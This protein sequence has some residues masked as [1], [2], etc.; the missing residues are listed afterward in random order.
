MSKRRPGKER[1]IVW[2]DAAP[3]RTCYLIDGQMPIVQELNPALTVNQAEYAGLARALIAAKEEGITNLEVRTDSQL[4]ARQLNQEYA[5]NNP[6]LLKC[7]QGIWEY[8]KQ[9]ESVVF[10]WI[11]REQNQ[12]GKVLG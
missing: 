4:A 2:T 3:T 8:V 12:A 7:A 1:T 11:P 6:T 9:F 5:I 10:V